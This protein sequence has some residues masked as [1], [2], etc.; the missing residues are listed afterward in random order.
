MK[1]FNYFDPFDSSDF[2]D[3]V[4]DHFRHLT[5]H[6]FISEFRKDIDEQIHIK[7]GIKLELTDAERKI[8]VRSDAWRLTKGCGVVNC[9]RLLGNK[10]CKPE[11]K[12]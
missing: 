12:G 7:R 5:F 4:F 10:L 9:F 11:D 2:S 1:S 3:D 8:W 6:Q